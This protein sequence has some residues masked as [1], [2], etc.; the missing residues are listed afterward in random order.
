MKLIEIKIPK[1]VLYLT[2]QEYLSALKR[3]KAIKRKQEL[4]KRLTNIVVHKNHTSH[5]FSDSTHID[6]G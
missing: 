2:E 5:S 1:A 3:G 4:I 6:N